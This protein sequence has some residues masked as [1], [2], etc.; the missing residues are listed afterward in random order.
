MKER[1]WICLRFCFVLFFCFWG[2][3]WCCWC[4]GYCWGDCSLFIFLIEVLWLNLVFLYYIFFLWFMSWFDDLV[5]RNWNI[6]WI[7]L[8]WFCY[9]NIFVFCDLKEGYLLCNLFWLFRK[10]RL[11]F[12]IIEICGEVKIGRLVWW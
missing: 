1:Y 8:K 11:Y 6:R 9:N 10:S 12:W 3:V 4:Y 5:C 2:D 7:I